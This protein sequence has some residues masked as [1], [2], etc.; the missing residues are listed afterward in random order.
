MR[1]K[2]TII[3]SIFPSPF[4][5]VNFDDY[6]NLNAR[7]IEYVHECKAVGKITNAQDGSTTNWGNGYQ[8]QL[9]RESVPVIEEFSAAVRQAFASYLNAIGLSDVKGEIRQ[10]AWVVVSYEGGYNAPHVHPAATFTSIYHVKV[11]PNLPYPQA[12]VEFIN[13]LG[14]ASF[15]SMGN[16]TQVVEPKEGTLLFIP[17]YL[18]HAV[19]PFEGEGERISLN[20]DFTIIQEGSSHLVA[21]I[22]RI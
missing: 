13:P 19:H 18:M 6:E 5:T 12:C 8:V 2:D 4:M 20:M 10:A 15:Q 21:G 11:P 22:Q 14:S 16:Q 7:I 3:T 17:S 9:F 1:I